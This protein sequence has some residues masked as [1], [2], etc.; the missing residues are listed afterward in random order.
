[1]RIKSSINFIQTLPLPLLFPNSAGQNVTF[2]ST[3]FQGIVGLGYL[4]DD[5][6]WAG[7]DYRY[8]STNN[9]RSN[10]ND[11]RGNVLN[12]THTRYAIN[13]INLTVSFIFNQT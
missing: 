4:L 11:F 10:D 3:A 1:A 9:L 13:T 12:F 7:I 5:Y 8:V 2:G 6:T